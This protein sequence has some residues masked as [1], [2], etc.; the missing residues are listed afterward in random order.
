MRPIRRM[1]FELSEIHD[2]PWFPDFL[3]CEVLDAL[4][5]VLEVTNAYRPIAERLQVALERAGARAVFDLF[6]GAGGPWPS[7][8]RLFEN[9][10]AQIPEVFLTDKYPNSTPRSGREPLTSRHIHFVRGAVDATGHSHEYRRI[11]N[12]VFVVP[13]FQCGRRTPVSGRQRGE[14]GGRWRFR[15]RFAADAHDALDIVY[16]RRR[17]D[18]HAVL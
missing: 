6:S 8:V 3:R 9:E 10:G 18:L 17:L 11:S 15:N 2:Q 14:R 16:S 4:Q 7:F 5:M 12:G 13:P 1:R